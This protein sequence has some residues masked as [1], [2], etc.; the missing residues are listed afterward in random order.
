[1][2]DV[3]GLPHISVPDA[4]PVTVAV[5][6]F[7]NNVVMVTGHGMHQSVDEIRSSVAGARKNR[8]GCS[9]VLWRY[10]Q[11]YL[12]CSHWSRSGIFKLTACD[13][14]ARSAAH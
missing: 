7:L 8:C 13:Q 1:M 6:A 12:S 5:Q 9:V 14:G 2:T 4:S 3:L 10:K 11:L